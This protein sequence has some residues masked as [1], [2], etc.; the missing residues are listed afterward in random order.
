MKFS[1][2]LISMILALLMLFTG[3]Q[4]TAFAATEKTYVKEVRISTAS[5]ESAAR[6]WLT[7][8]GYLVLDVNLNQK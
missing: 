4:I 3:L 6:Q 7:K 2:R 8:N 5:D 1:T